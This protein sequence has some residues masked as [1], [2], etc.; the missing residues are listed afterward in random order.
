MPLF[1]IVHNFILPNTPEFREGRRNCATFLIGAV[2][3]AVLYGIVMHLKYLYGKVMDAMLS[4]LVLIIMADAATM[5]VEYRLYYGRTILHELE[6]EDVE[7]F[8]FDQKTHK[9]TRKTR[10]EIEEARLEKLVLH[11]KNKRVEGIAHEKQRIRAAKVIQRWW[12]A[13][14]YNPPDGIIYL[15][16]NK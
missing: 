3:Y 1:Y 15:R 2:T 16:A 7:T 10:E 4:A 13:R 8:A 9:Y 5:A 6:D 14:L 12:R 11:E